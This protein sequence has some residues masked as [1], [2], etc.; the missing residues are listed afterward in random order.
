M[1]NCTDFRRVEWGM[2][3]DL[4]PGEERRIMGKTPEPDVRPGARG[5][6]GEPSPSARGIGKEVRPI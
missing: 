2:V 1:E 6:P 5:E 4:R 3:G